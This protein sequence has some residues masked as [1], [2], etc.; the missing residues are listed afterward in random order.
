MH[1]LEHMDAPLLGKINDS[2]ASSL[3]VEGVLS[4]FEIPIKSGIT[5]EVWFREEIVD[6]LTTIGLSHPDAASV[7]IVFRKP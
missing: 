1:Y 5:G 4:T 2:P 3:S 6:A 7:L